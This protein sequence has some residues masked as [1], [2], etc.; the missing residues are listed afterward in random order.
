M[1]TA[2]FIPPEAGFL[3]T[4]ARELWNRHG[5]N[6]AEV[7][8]LLPTR[9][10]GLYLTYYLAREK[11]GPFLPPRIQALADFINEQAV[12][13]D[14]RPVIPPAERAWWLYQIVRAWPALRSLAESFD[15]FLPWGLRLAEVLEEFEKEE[16]PV[17]DL[18]HPP[19]ELPELAR[20]LLGHLAEISRRYREKLQANRVTTPAERLRRLSEGLSEV[21][22]SGKYYLCGFSALSRTEK[23]IFQI[24]LQRGAEIFFEGHPKELPPF[25]EEIL[26]DLELNPAYL[27]KFPRR[28]PKIT[29]HVAADVHQEC[30]ALK[31]YLSPSVSS[32]DEILILLPVAGH[33]LPL[34]YTLP[35]G[36]SLNVTLGYPVRRSLPA[37]FLLLLLDLYEKRLGDRYPVL[38][39]LA[40]LKHPYLRL[41]SGME[42]GLRELEWR[43]REHGSP[44]LSLEEIE[45]LGEGYPLKR[46]HDRVLRVWQKIK[47]PRQMAEAL[48][49][50]LE[51]VL[52]PQR[53]RL[54]L[55]KDQQDILAR[56]F[57]WA[58]E[59]EILPLFSASA[60]AEE[61]LQPETLFRLFRELLTGLKAP[62]EGEPL[63]GVQVMGLLE[64]RLLSFRRVIV[65]DANEG[66]LPSPE[67]VNPLL[68]EGL[69]P[70]LGLPPRSRQEALERYHFQRLIRA[71]REVEIFYLSVTETSGRRPPRV[72]SRYVEAL[73]WEEER[74]RRSLAGEELLRRNPSVPVAHSPASGWP[75]G[76]AE[77]QEVEKWLR[78]REISA[79]FLETYLDCPLKFYFRY[80]LGLKPPARITDYDAGELGSLI[81]EVLEAYFRPYEGKFYDPRK[82]NSPERLLASFRERFSQSVLFRRLGPERRFFILR[83]AE[84]RLKRYLEALREFPPFRILAL[85]KEMRREHPR[86][87][88]RFYGRLDRVDEFEGEIVILD[89]KTGGNIRSLNLKRLRTLLGE[90]LTASPD[91][92][93]LLFLRERMPDLQ[94]LLYLFLHEEA[95][96]AAYVHLAAGKDRELFKPLLYRW[97]FSR[98][99]DG[100]RKEEVRRLGEEVFPRLLE[101]LI[102]HI[103]KAPAFYVPEPPPRCRFCDYRYACPGRR[104]S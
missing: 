54:R 49:E 38:N 79:T 20:E 1:K 85:E 101:L 66:A 88:L 40:L 100:L 61:P 96:E 35:E 45:D 64:T 9:R 2:F 22:P 81:H 87:G 62:L 63:K 46:L 82:D 65:L 16:V 10:A 23:K 74:R 60:F 86:L 51:E 69:R 21:L 98:S 28:R 14:P 17:K 67:E 59:S 83:T 99:R 103:L 84:F 73:I 75:K 70:A 97:P 5:E 91:L 33:L 24:L 90:E 94:L 12:K 68:P 19:E 39:Y 57:L 104:G 55:S 43:L 13:L 34:L 50:I 92:E 77:R 53:E 71:S 48:F 37:S 102:E 18:P 80:V 3:R 56:Y 15:R 47:T 26:K 32:P 31:K 6:L 25:V 58:L 42:E 89:Y 52:A 4:L 36:L 29:F 7:T 95:Q 27:R 78:E 72:R 44:Y 93:G 30:E 11:K 41:W 76:E 8:V